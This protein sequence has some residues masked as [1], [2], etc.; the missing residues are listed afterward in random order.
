MKWSA[1]C[2]HYVTEHYTDS[3]GKWVLLFVQIVSALMYLVSEI[4]ISTNFDCIN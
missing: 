2:Y 3:K 1:E 4:T